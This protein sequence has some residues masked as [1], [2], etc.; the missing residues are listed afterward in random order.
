MVIGKIIN[1][2]AVIVGL[3]AGI[4]LFVLSFTNGYWTEV[5]KYL[6]YSGLGLIFGIVVFLCIAPSD[7]TVLYKIAYMA[8]VL[9][10][11]CF[12]VIVCYVSW[13]TFVRCWKIGLAFLASI[14][15]SFIGE[16]LVC[17]C[18]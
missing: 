18:E 7:D 16:A 2:L 5:L 14:I 10:L 13:I 6:A 11:F 9:S 8:I 1:G 15:L 17:A 3:I 12:I 4:V